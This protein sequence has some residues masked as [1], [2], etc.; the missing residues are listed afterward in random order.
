M[1]HIDLLDLNH[2]AHFWNQKSGFLFISDVCYLRLDF[3]SFT[4]LGPADAVETGG[5]ACT[6]DT[7][8]VTVSY[9]I[10]LLNEMRSTFCIFSF[11]MS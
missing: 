7:F 10:E 9:C 11:V 1:I 4:L 5:G 8:K 3:E 2:E 6:R